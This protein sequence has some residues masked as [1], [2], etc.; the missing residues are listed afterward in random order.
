MLKHSPAR[1]SLATAA[2]LAFFVVLTSPATA[3]TPAGSASAGKLEG[4]WVT[5]VTIRDCQTG[6]PLRSFPAL[7]TFNEGQ[8]MIDTTTGASASTR[9]PGLGKW[10]KTGPKTYSATTLAFLFSAVGTWTGTQKLTHV[11]QASGREITFTS[12]VEITDIA[13]NVTVNGC[14]TAVG[15]KL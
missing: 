10:E 4:T 11:I 5:Q 7:N 15:Q 9:T 6:F 12:T 14:A 1:I 13:G 2:T 3:Q 8:T